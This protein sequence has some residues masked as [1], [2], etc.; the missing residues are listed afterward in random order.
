MVN[1]LTHSVLKHGVREKNLTVGLYK[2]TG[3]RNGRVV[4]I[5]PKGGYFCYNPGN[6]KHYIVDK[7]RE[8]IDF[9]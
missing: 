2:S 3:C 8:N 5:G 4:Y 1:S 9:Y 7:E 6:T